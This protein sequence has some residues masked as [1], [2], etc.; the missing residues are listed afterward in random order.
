M[1]WVLFETLFQRHEHES[2]YE[3]FLHTV[4][5][6]Q[7]KQD[8]YLVPKCVLPQPVYLVWK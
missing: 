5:L 2:V 3:N 6:Y 7:E 4:T 1:S 8:L